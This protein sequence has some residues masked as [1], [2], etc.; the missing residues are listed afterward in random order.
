MELPVRNEIVRAKLTVP[1]DNMELLATI[2][3]HLEYQMTELEHMYRK[4][5]FN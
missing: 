1:N 2:S 5:T 4:D 3:S